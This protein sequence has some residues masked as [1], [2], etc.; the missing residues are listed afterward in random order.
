[1]A[2]LTTIDCIYNK[3]WACG[4]QKVLTGLVYHITTAGVC[5]SMNTYIPLS[6]F[7]KF[8]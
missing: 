8:M 6:A 4:L 2:A 5:S 3:I 1:M 7:E